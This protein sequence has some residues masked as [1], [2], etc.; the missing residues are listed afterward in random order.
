MLA[1]HKNSI[2]QPQTVALLVRFGTNLT[3][4]FCRFSKLI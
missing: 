1:K 3:Q 2:I 4:S